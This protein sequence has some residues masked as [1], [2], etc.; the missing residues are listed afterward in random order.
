MLEAADRQRA[1][2]EVATGHRRIP[3]HGAGICQAGLHLTPQDRRLIYRTT[4][5]C[6][7]VCVCV[8]LPMCARV[9]YVFA[10]S[11]I[12]E[13]VLSA[14]RRIHQGWHFLLFPVQTKH[15]ATCAISS[16][17]DVERPDLCD[18]SVRNYTIVTPTHWFGTLP[19]FIIFPVIGNLVGQ[20]FLSS[21]PD[22]ESW[23]NKGAPTATWSC[24]LL[25]PQGRSVGH[26]W[27]LF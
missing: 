1:D 9:S 8:Y 15:A 7:C 2:T 3:G 16:L 6:V 11:P 12:G 20:T 25:T 13:F 21:L 18:L 22:S 26:D 10:H 23:N 27:M 24:L 17:R 19:F 14:P 4:S 5:V